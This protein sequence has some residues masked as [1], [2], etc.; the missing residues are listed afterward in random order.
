MAVFFS[1][2]WSL[3]PRI[4]IALPSS[5]SSLWMYNCA[6]FDLFSAGCAFIFEI[7]GFCP[8]LPQ[9]A[10]SIMVSGFLGATEAP[11]AGRSSECCRRQDCPTLTRKRSWKD[12]DSLIFCW[13]HSD[14]L[15]ED[16]MSWC[17]RT[18]RQGRPLSYTHTSWLLASLSSLKLLS[19]E[20][21]LVAGL[22]GPRKAGASA[23]RL[24]HCSETDMKVLNRAHLWEGTQ[25]LVTS[26]FSGMCVCVWNWWGGAPLIQQA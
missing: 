11:P 15:L 9:W 24:A 10:L 7:V 12:L 19:S 14:L 21:D 4:L 5:R 17:F 16:L 2:I 23:I 6:K 8:F 22:P 18:T 13:H 20:E 1:M 26:S 3:W 25:L